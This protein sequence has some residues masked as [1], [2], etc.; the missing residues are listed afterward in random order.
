MSTAEH[1]QPEFPQ[2]PLILVMDSFDGQQ[3]HYDHAARQF[4]AKPNLRTLTYF[5]RAITNLSTIFEATATAVIQEETPIEL[6]ATCISELCVGTDRR[7]VTLFKELA[8]KGN[9]FYFPQTTEEYSA[10]IQSIL[11]TDITPDKKIATLAQVYQNDIKT[12]S[13]EFKL[14]ILPFGKIIKKAEQAKNDHLLDIGKYAAGSL[15][16]TL[17]AEQITKKR[18]T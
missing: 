2:D 8:P 15:I 13:K 16:A 10:T 18:N 9:F 6:K 11:A 4:A 12:D 14:A 17:L 3:E 1:E 7:R 5:N